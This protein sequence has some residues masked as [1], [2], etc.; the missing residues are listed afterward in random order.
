VGN[1]WANGSLP[2]LDLCE[3]GTV[4]AAR[5]DEAAVVLEQRAEGD[6]GLDAYSVLLDRID[7]SNPELFETRR[8]R[9]T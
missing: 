9:G 1:R 7:V 8:N 4:G 5:V 2:T 3:L 6:A